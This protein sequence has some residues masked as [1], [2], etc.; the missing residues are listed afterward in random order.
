MPS[1]IFYLKSL[2]KSISYIGDV[3][4]VFIITMSRRNLWI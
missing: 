1:G 3:W 4:V 2:D